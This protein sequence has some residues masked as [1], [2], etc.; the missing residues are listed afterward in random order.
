MGRGEVG[1]QPRESRQGLTHRAG[2]AKARAWGPRGLLSPKAGSR[3]R[4]WTYP[5]LMAGVWPGGWLARCTRGGGGYLGAVGPSR[6]GEEGGQKPELQRRHR[7]DFREDLDRAEGGRRAGSEVKISKVSPSGD[8]GKVCR[9]VWHV[10]VAEREG[11]VAG[12]GDDMDGE[13]SNKA[14]LRPQ[15]TKGMPKVMGA[16]VGEGQAD[17]GRRY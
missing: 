1:G 14:E 16:R 7:R 5:L 2:Q 12:H 3:R 9:G 10:W 13:D 11:Q 8:K 4:R 6:S 17:G 15:G